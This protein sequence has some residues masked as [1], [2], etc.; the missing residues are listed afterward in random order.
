MYNVYTYII[1]DRYKYYILCN[2]R[3][4]YAIYIL[5]NVR[6]IYI[7]Y[8]YIYCWTNISWLA[9]CALLILSYA[10]RSRF[11]IPV[12]LE[13]NVIVVTVLLFIRYEPIGIPFGDYFRFL[14]KR[15]T[16]ATITFLAICKESRICFRQ[17]THD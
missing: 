1:F 5:Y 16:E 3:Q 13:R 12:I 2:R 6:Q 14:I 7:I 11:V 17:C 15:K 9:L 10:Q 8:I 4:I